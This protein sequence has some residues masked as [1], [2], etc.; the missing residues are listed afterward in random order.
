MV[1]PM[2]PPWRPE[3]P[4]GGGGD[5]GHG[6]DG[7]VPVPEELALVPP[8]PLLCELLDELPVDG[9]SGYGTVQ[10]LQAAYRQ[11]C[12]DQAVFFSILRETGLRRPFSAG[13]VERVDRPGEFACEEARAALVWS[14]WRAKAAWV[15]AAD[16]FD[17]LP[18]LGKAM[19]AGELDEPRARAFVEWTEGLTDEQANQVVDQLLPQAGSLVVGALVDRIKQM[20]LA[21]DPDWAGKKYR[22]AVRTRRVAGFRNPDGTANLGGYQQPVDRVAAACARIDA[23]AR[24]CKRAGDRRKIDLVRSDLYLR[25]LDGTFEGLSD[26]EIID[27]VLADPY[28][29]PGDHDPNNPSD[30]PGGGDGPDGDRRGDGPTGGPGGQPAG[31]DGP[32]DGSGAGEPAGSEPPDRDAPGVQPAGDNGSA[33]AGPSGDGSGADQPAGGEPADRDAPGAG[34]TNNPSG[35]HSADRPAVPDGAAASALAGAGAVVR[36]GTSWAVPELRV[37]LSTMLG[38]DEYPAELPAWD[39][40]PAWLARHLLAGMHA[41][42]WRYVICGDDGRPIDGGLLGSRPH[43]AGGRAGRDRRRGGIVELAVSTAEL[44]ALSRHPGGRH[45]TWNPVITALIDAYPRHRADTTRHIDPGRGAANPGGGNTHRGAWNP[46]EPDGGAHHPGGPDGR[47]RDPTD[48]HRRTAGTRLRRWVQL[49]DRSCL[50]PGCRAPAA[51]TDQDHRLGHAAGGPTT[52]ANLDSACRHDHRVKDEG[53]WIVHRAT[54]DLAVWASPLGHR[55][56][57]RPPPVIVPL[58]EPWPDPHG[59]DQLPTGWYHYPSSS[60]ADCGCDE[61][62][63]CAEPLLPPPPVRRPDPES[64]PEPAPAPIFDPDEIPPF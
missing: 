2:G 28:V 60:T 62:C 52:A 20:C 46:G 7:P 13:T 29:D 17:R 22:A 11:L 40:V 30:D 26:A 50:F 8:G 35:G 59:R 56:P 3:E 16:V 12:R 63:D 53:G 15:F 32:G 18:A 55:Y 27:Y 42:E 61:P 36:A 10:L 19:L 43:P 38:L 58:P 39:Y 48:P 4:A 6:G 47:D 5:Q 34:P 45:T 54:H 23:L 31:G 44:E 21:I 14:R 64:Q 9:V 57:S 41:A 1:P 51:G 33:D 37:R 25:M 24:A 49:R